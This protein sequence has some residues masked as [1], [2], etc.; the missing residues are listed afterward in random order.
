LPYSRQTVGAAEAA[1]VAAAVGDAWLTGGATLARFE[2]RLAEV[3]GARHAIA[4]S[5]GTAALHTAYLAAGVGRGDTVLTSPITFVA[6]AS[7]AVLC[8]AT[9]AFA[10]TDERG[11]LD[12]VAVAAAARPRVVVPVHY[13]GHPA[14]VAAIAAAA[15]GAL[16]IEDA[17]HALGSREGSTAIGAC[18]DAAMA[19]FSFHAVKTITTGAGGAVVTT[20]AE[21]GARG[22]RLRDH[23]LVRDQAALADADGP[24]VYEQQ[25]SG[26]NYR[27]TDIQAALGLAQLARLD[28]FVARRQAI[29]RCYDRL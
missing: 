22:R 13:A 5:S 3:V 16:V 20:D 1:A 10:D 26:L 23:A 29:A 6:T 24:W 9:P 14:P 12:P 4:V 28:E 11:N 27:L 7:A 25:E 18:R 15:P 2:V 8:G 19:V 21:P 17:C